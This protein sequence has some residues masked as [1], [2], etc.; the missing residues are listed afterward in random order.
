MGSTACHRQEGDDLD[1][2]RRLGRQHGEIDVVEHDH[3]PGCRLVAPPDLLVRHLGAVDRADAL[4]L[5]PATVIDMNLV[6]GNVLALGRHVQPNRDRHQAEG[7][8][9]SPYH[10][11][12]RILSITR[13]I[14]PYTADHTPVPLHCLRGLRKRATP[15]PSAS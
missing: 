15:G 4:V 6:G 12:R 7:D 3:L 1:R 9:A 5:H 8:G 14:R 11:H 2:A 13:V 10:P